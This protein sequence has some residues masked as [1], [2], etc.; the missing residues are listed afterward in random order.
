ML[1]KNMKQ[2]N[3][4]MSRIYRLCTVANL[5]LVVRSWTGIYQDYTD[6]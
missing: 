4:L 3:Q 1:E 6:R 5:A 2:V